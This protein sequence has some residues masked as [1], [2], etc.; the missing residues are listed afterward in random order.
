[1]SKYDKEIENPLKDYQGRFEEALKR[2]I[3]YNPKLHKKDTT[4][5]DSKVQKKP[6]RPKK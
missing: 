1:M 5:K 4:E 3:S 2:I 6:I